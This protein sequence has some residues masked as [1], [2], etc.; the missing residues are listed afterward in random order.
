MIF[1]TLILTISV[2]FS[3]NGTAQSIFTRPADAIK[4]RQSAFHVMG[5]HSQRIGSMAKGEHPFDK[6]IA[7]Q[8]AAIIDMLA[9]QLESAFPAGTDIPPSK[10]KLEVW[11]DAASF[12]QKMDD[13]KS[14]ARK[15]TEATRSGDLGSIRSAF[16]QTA[17][18][19]KSCHE[20]FR[21][22]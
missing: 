3:Q 20:G 13:L 8:D 11:Q 6:S 10:A 4:Y 18:S 21:N 15:L 7:I 22:R 12:K 2:L 19:C 5:F 16:N 1:R 14:S 17:Q 9:A